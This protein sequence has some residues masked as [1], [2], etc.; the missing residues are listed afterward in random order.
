MPESF[1]RWILWGMYLRRNKKKKGGEAYEYWS[2]VESVRSARGPRQRTVATIG[3]LPGLDTEERLGWEEIRRILTGTPR[4][5]CK[6]FEKEEEPPAW[7]TID[8][9]RVSVERLR[10]FGDVYLGLLLWNKLGFADFCTAHLPEGREE[11]PWSVMAS[12]LVC[13]RFCAPSSELQ[14]ADSWYDKTA[15]DDLLGVPSDKINDDRLYRSLDVLLPYKDHLCRHLQNR[16]G[17]LF[18]TTFDF[19]FYD[20]TSTYVEGNANSNPQAKRGYSRDSRPDCPQ[21]CIGLVATKEGLPLAFEIFDGNRPDVTTT[22]EMVAVMEAKY[23]KAHRIWVMDRGMVSEDNLEFMRMTGARYLVGTPKSLLRKFE[24]HLLGQDW[25]EVQPGVEVRLCPCPEGTDETFVLCRS[26]RRK[27]K[28]NAILARFATRLEEKLMR[29]AERA[30]TGRLR[31]RQKVERQIGRLLER[32]SR[33]A[34]LFTVTVSEK[35]DRLAID[36]KK[37]EEHY[38]WAMETGGSY[39]LRTN[40]TETDPKTLW[41]TYIQLTEVE[42]AFR[43]VKHDLGMRPIYHHKQDRT[44]AHILV[45]FLSLALWRTLQQWMKTS[46]LGTTPRKLLE[47]MREIRSLDVL[48]P[49]RDKTIR[50]RVAATPSPELKVLLQRMKLLLPN[51]PKIIENV[52]A[53]IDPLSA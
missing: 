51:R 10:H 14:I 8:I 16:Y 31:D 2:L 48:L 49:T 34:S 9:S 20:I 36:I 25:E 43:T 52:V 35:K 39:I 11:I 45:C 37:H 44:Q 13:A 27:E 33:A 50:L 21:V 17:E 46:G 38:R 6:L 3:K 28:E 5:G 26:Q 18:G 22:Q 1:P 47:E 12:I 15:L 53:K 7:A 19:L 29:L 40:W 4:P 23:G 24:A 42:D 30:D 32:N 41:N